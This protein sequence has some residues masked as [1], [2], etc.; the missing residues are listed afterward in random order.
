MSSTQSARRASGAGVL[1][2]AYRLVTLGS[3]A[4]VF[5]TAFEN[6]AVATVMPVISRQLD[7]ANLYAVAFAG[8]LAIGVVGM[9]LAGAWSD[10]S[11]PR[12]P[13][14]VSVVVFAIGLVIAGTAPTMAVVVAGRLVYGLAGGAIS[15]ALYVVV[16][17]IY[18]ASL[19]PSIFGGF[20][21]AWIIPALIGPAIAGIL[22][23]TVGWR[24]VFLGAVVLV[25][26]AAVM[27][28]PVLK[29]LGGPSD[30]AP[31]FV[32]SRVAWSCLLAVSVLGLSLAGEL[33]TLAAIPVAAVALALALWS[34]RPLLPP[35]TLRARRGLPSVIGLRMI[36]AASY[37]GAEI[38]LPYLLT[39]EFGLSPAIAG[40]S[41]TGAAVAWGIAS[42]VQG[43]S[44][45]GISV[46]ASILFGVTTVIVAILLPLATAALQL[47]PLVA[48]IGWTVGGIGMGMV[49]PR[50]SVA[51]LALSTGADRGFNSA[52]LSIADA[53][54][55]AIALAVIGIL[56]Q[57][58][59]PVTGDPLAFSA[60]F[61]VD[62]ALGIG[63]LL[64]A[65]RV[66]LSAARA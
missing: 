3:L 42:W 40:L 46:R 8:P 45:G 32:P 63:A 47:S 35:G 44:S 30:D 18:P 39:S 28:A 53:V 14:I 43:R 52:A 12:T 10:R 55:P 50:L 15:V 33:P 41:L 37:F 21:A 17:R 65:R 31:P 38:Y 9:V 6:L 59:Q 24:W 11:G 2:P 25:G 5:L 64:V 34:V 62:L 49:L 20:A 1:A 23:Q 22:A 54:G 51:M 58:L 27:I 56:F 4:I 29:H 61:T 66:A 26:F 7:G 16:G 36:L 57:N 19:Q 13:L 60:T 48:I